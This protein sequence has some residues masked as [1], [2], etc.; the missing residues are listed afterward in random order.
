MK[1][2]SEY[3]SQALAALDG[4]WIFGA[5]VTVIYIIVMGVPSSVSSNVQLIAAGSI[6]TLLLL[7]LEYGYNILWLGV[8]RDEKVD[9]GTLFDGFKDYLRVLLTLFLTGIYTFL[10][11]LLLIVPGIVKAYSY[12]M[13]PYVLKDNPQLSYDAAIENSM[14]L[15]NGHKMKLFLLDLSFI[16]WGILC[17]LSLGIGFLFLSPYMECAHA[18]FYEDLIKEGEEE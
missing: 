9:Y 8:I 13:T 17:L 6:V 2:I 18:S 11:S 1:R 14:C 7:P 3:K 5:L 15:M 16:G 4:K 12:C 10:W